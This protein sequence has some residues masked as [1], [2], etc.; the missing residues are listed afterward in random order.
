MHF[1]FV[2]A[3]ALCLAS[4]AIGE[5]S[6]SAVSR[7]ETVPSP[8]RQAPLAHE[9]GFRKLRTVEWVPVPDEGWEIEAASAGNPA[10]RL[11]NGQWDF[12]IRE[13]HPEEAWYRIRDKSWWA[14]DKK[15]NALVEVDGPRRRHPYDREFAK[16]DGEQF[17][18]NGEPFLIRGVTR[19]EI[20]Q[21]VGRSLSVG[22]MLNE[23]RLMREA[24]ING[25]RS[26]PYPFDPRWIK[27]CAPRHPGLLGLL[28]VRL[29]FLG[30]PVGAVRGEDVPNPRSR[31]RS[32]LPRAVPGPLPLLR[33]ADL[34]AAEEYDG[35]L[36]LEPVQ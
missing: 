10:V 28:P 35:G 6:M 25:V 16:P 18:L 22:D 7:S 26:H 17:L 14:W 4:N 1:E 32:R 36:C 8:T 12:A 24:N 2:G 23:I 3:L 21:G 5:V 34:R 33:P 27:L 19:H 9:D 15:R 20:K 29:Q 13:R 11:L 30:Q 31:D